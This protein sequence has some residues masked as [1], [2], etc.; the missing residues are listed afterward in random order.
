MQGVYGG[1]LRDVSTKVARRHALDEAAHV[2]L[3]RAAYEGIRAAAADEQHHVEVVRRQPRLLQGARNGLQ[4]ARRA[5]RA[6]LAGRRRGGEKR[7]HDLREL[8]EGDLRLV[9]GPRPAPHLDNVNAIGHDR[10]RALTEVGRIAG[11]P[12]LHHRNDFVPES[13]PPSDSGS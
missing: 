1:A 7:L 10:I 12:R 11:A 5:V 13:E 2:P 8:A 4:D 6:V 9:E 3:D